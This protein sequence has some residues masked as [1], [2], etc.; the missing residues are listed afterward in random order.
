MYTSVLSLIRNVQLRHHPTGS[1]FVPADVTAMEISEPKSPRSPI[2]RTVELSRPTRTL[3]VPLAHHHDCSLT[4]QTTKACLLDSPED[5]RSPNKGTIKGGP[6]GR[7]RRAP[8]CI[9]ISTSNLR[10][11]FCA[12]PVRPSVLLYF[13]HGRRCSTLQSITCGHVK[14]DLSSSQRK[15]PLFAECYINPRGFLLSFLSR[16]ASLQSPP[17][18]LP[19]LPLVPSVQDWQHPA[20]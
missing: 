13:G 11:Q 9:C 1:A 8:A 12:F 14:C 16:I 4:L 19:A 17:P 15:I 10:R 18:L 7:L 2:S 3:P 20:R 5:R 6:M